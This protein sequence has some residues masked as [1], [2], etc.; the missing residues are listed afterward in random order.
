MA[1]V[2]NE[3]AEELQ[4]QVFLDAWAKCGFKCGRAYKF[5]HPDVT[6]ESA[7]VMGSRMLSKINLEEV[8]E[9]R[10]LGKDRYYDVLEEGLKATRTVSGIGDANEKSIEFVDVPDYRTIREYHK[11]L[12]K[13]LRVEIDR[14]EVDNHHTFAQPIMEGAS[15]HEDNSD[16][17]DIQAS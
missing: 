8:L 3:E 10:N 1:D 11:A 13:A 4:K 17:E 5:L 15:V 9:M 6:D 2:K 7:K 16:K 12:G 14:S